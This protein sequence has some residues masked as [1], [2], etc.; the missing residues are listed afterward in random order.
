VLDGSRGAEKRYHGNQFLAFD[1]HGCMI[2]SD[3]L[4]DSWG[5]FSGQAIRR[6]HSRD[7][8]S[9]GRCHDNQFLD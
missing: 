5:G 8:V 3:A 6:R 7:R 4:F 2:A 9:K 1:G